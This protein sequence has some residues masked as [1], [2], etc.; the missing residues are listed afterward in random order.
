MSTKQYFSKPIKKQTMAEQMADNIQES[1]LFGEL[2]GGAVLPTEPELAQQ[3]GVSRAV[4]RD[5]TRILMARGLVQVEHGRGVFVTQPDNE[6]FGD[7]LLLALRRIGASAWDVEQFDQTIFPEVLALAATNARDEEIAQIQQMADEYY[8][9][10]TNHITNWSGNGAPAA[11]EVR[12]IAAYQRV[13]QAIFAATHN[14]VFQQ[15]AR[16]LLRL[17]N[18]R[19]WAEGEDE[20]REKYVEVEMNYMRQLISAIVSRDQAHARQSAARLMELPPEAIK[21]MRQT[22]VGEIVEIPISMILPG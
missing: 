14:R 19:T 1:I 17:R 10:V 9:I 3:F 22:Q 4:V 11:E 16:P 5:A 12:M 15:L 7:A 2:P 6:A 21:A 13:L 8:E 18:L 20:S